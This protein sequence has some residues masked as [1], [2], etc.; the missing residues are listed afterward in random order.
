MRGK[1]GKT[2]L[3]LTDS[4]EFSYRDMTIVVTPV[5]LDDGNR[6]L[7]VSV[8]D[9]DGKNVSVNDARGLFSMIGQQIFAA[10]DTT[11]YSILASHSV[12]YVLEGG[13]SA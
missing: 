10:N 8:K 2:L 3:A 13:E 1:F 6:G 5:D 7:C 9:S 4:T 12:M 11:G